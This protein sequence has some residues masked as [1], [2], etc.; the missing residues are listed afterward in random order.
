LRKAKIDVSALLLIL[1]VFLLAVGIYFAV[2]YLRPDPVRDSLSGEKVIST[3][4]VIENADSSQNRPLASYVLMYSPE[5]RRAAIFDIPG[6]VGLLLQRGNLVGRI[7][8]VYDPR[9]IAPFLQ[10]TEGLLGLEISFYVLISLENLGK[11]VD[12]IE[13]V[14]LF[15][16]TQVNDY[17]DGHILF[18]SGI[19]RLDGDKAKLY[20]TYELPEENEDFANVRRQ[21]FFMGFIKRLGEQ[22][23]FLN[24]QNVARFFHSLVRTGSNRQI[25]ARLFDEFAKIDIDRASIQTVS[26]NVREV[27]GQNLI[28]PHWDG[29]LIKEI[30]R[31]TQAGLAQPAGNMLGDRVFTVEILNG[32]TISGL[33]GRTAE[34]FRGFGYDIVS[35]SN[36][37]RNDYERT[38]VIDRSGYQ[39][40]VRTFAGIIR[41]TNISYNSPEIVE[42]DIDLDLRIFEHRADITLILGRDFN[43]RFVTN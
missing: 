28:F 38:I 9:R 40:V 4:F 18:P 31:Q 30:V 21:H 35:I 1:I 5:T 34:L 32:T 26:G 42:T 37:D 15:I 6:S 10:E 29:S 11:L 27:S 39:N 7:D 22:N 3:L 41:C 33:A 2:Y 24:H 36:A 43:G 23:E 13:G 19:N 14:E 12:L 8:S 16:P 20:I 25:Q 17:Q